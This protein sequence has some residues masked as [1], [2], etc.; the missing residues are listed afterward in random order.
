MCASRGTRGWSCPHAG[1]GICHRGG[2]LSSCSRKSRSHKGI[3]DMGHPPKTGWQSANTALSSLPFRPRP[4]LAASCEWARHSCRGKRRVLCASGPCSGA[5]SY[6]TNVRRLPAEPRHR[7]QA[8]R[9]ALLGLGPCSGMAWR[10]SW[11]GPAERKFHSPRLKDSSFLK[12]LGNGIRSSSSSSGINRSR[13]SCPMTTLNQFS[14]SLIT[15]NW[16]S[17]A[18]PAR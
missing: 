8:V 12:E 14:R 3:G 18:V 9:D 7:E 11:L 6:P 5:A 16:R 13:S 10:R 4:R 17:S 15:L 2:S 1:D